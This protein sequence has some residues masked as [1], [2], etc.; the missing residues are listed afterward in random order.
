MT[1]ST[2]T[3][4]VR[5]VVIA[6]L[7]FFVIGVVLKYFYRDRDNPVYSTYKDLVPILLG[8]PAAYLAYCF[9]LRNAHLQT[10]RSLW[11]NAIKAIQKARDYCYLRELTYPEYAATL[12]GLSAVIDEVR[13][14]FKNLGETDKEIGLYPFEPLK[15]IFKLVQALKPETTTTEQQKHE[16]KKRIDAH[17]RQLRTKF[18]RELERSEPDHPESRYHTYEV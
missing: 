11:S 10:L 15:D 2:L 4:A 18:L 6:L 9:N 5:K 14:V 16:T 13:G 1:R 17:W 3:K 12:G 7:A 8:I